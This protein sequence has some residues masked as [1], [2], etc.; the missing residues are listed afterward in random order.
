MHNLTIAGLFGRL[1]S[2]SYLLPQL[3]TLTYM[4]HVTQVITDL[5]LAFVNRVN[6]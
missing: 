4:G 3:P 1:T 2:A 5:R 6:A